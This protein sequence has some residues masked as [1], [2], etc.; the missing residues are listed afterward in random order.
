MGD[1][2]DGRKGDHKDES[3]GSKEGEY[4]GGNAHKKMAI[5]ARKMAAKACFI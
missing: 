2:G 3:G 4:R 1:H 5:A